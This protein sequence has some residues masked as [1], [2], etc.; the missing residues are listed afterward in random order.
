ANMAQYADRLDE[1]HKAML[2]TFPDYKLNVYE[3]RRTCTTPQFVFGA[4]QNNARVGKLTQ[5]GEGV[6]GAIMG[7]PFPIA[8]NAME[9]IWNEK[10]RFLTHKATR[11][12]NA[13]AP[14]ISSRF[15]TR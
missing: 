5:D 1:G 13:T 9:L 8:N 15:K 3:S 14:T 7:E 4:T 10:L 2:K 11:P 12:C 6:T